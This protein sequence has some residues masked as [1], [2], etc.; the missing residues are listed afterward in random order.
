M[1]SQLPIISSLHSISDEFASPFL[2]PHY[3]QSTW[4]I[5]S[6]LS[7]NSDNLGYQW[8]ICRSQYQST[9]DPYESRSSSNIEWISDQ[10]K[11][12]D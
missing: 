11:G 12:S 6:P 3:T 4:I 2:D 9:W 1:D 8:T 10:T 5:C 7:K